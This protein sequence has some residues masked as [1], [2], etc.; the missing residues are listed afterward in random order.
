MGDKNQLP[1]KRILTVLT[2]FL[3]FLFGKNHI[4]SLPTWHGLC[5]VISVGRRAENSPPKGGGPLGRG[6]AGFRQSYRTQETKMKNVTLYNP[7]SIQAT[8][9]DLDRY[10][11]SFFGDSL[12]SHSNRILDQMPRMPAVDV[13]ETEDAY[14]LEMELAGYDEKNIEIHVDGGNLTISSTR[15]N[16]REEKK[17]AKA[18]EGNYILRERKMNS[19]TRSF[20]MPEN[21]DPEAVKASFKNGILIMDIKKRAESKKRTIQITQG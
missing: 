19:F 8:L 10:I 1:F 7:N 11:E 9:N 2:A 17:D 5:Y 21:A 15:E 13:R 20:R 14:V 3:P 4:F 16:T 18:E 6:N 12:L